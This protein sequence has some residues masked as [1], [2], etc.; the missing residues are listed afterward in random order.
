M[1]FGLAS[2]EKLVN[3]LILCV[4]GFDATCIATTTLNLEIVRAL[5]R[6]GIPSIWMPPFLHGWLTCERNVI[7]A[8]VFIMAKAI[9]SGFVPVLHKDAILDEVQDCTILGGYV[10]IHPLAAQLKSEYV[11]CPTDIHGACD[12][13]LEH[14]LSKQPGQLNEER[15]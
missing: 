14:V 2:E 13:L 8:D 9:D 15:L 10:I 7:S 5:A 12:Y 4:N 11:V 6:E 3:H 1:E